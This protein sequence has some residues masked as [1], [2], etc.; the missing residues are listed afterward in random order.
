MDGLSDE[1]RDAFE[2]HYFECARCFEELQA[3]QG[4][5]G[6]LSCGGGAD[7]SPAPDTRSFGGLPLLDWRPLSCSR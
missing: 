1:D 7:P 5:R 6:E 2:E 4:I 3:L